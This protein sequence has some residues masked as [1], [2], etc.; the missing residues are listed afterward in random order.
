MNLNMGVLECE[1]CQD[2]FSCRIGMS[3]RHTQEFNITCKN[4]GSIASIVITEDKEISLAGVR[5]VGGRVEEGNSS[6]HLDLHLDFPVFESESWHPFSPFM[7]S[8]LMG[9]ESA[10]AQHAYNMNSLNDISSRYNFIKNTLN[11]YE[12]KKHDLFAR[13]SNEYLGITSEV[14]TDIGA[15]ML[16]FKLLFELLDPFLS[17]SEVNGD[18]G[19]FIKS[20]SNIS[21]SKLA[22]FLKEVTANKATENCILDAVKIYK[23]VLE[24]EVILR[25]A[26]F[27]DLNSNQS[28]SKLPYMLSSEG[29]EN[30][31]DLFKDI[32]EVLSRQL[33]FVAGINNLIKRGSHDDFLI[34]RSK[35]GNVLSPSSLQKFADLDFGKKLEFIDDSWYQISKDVADNQLRNSTAHFKWDYDSVNQKVTYFPKKEGLGRLQ[36][37]EISLLDYTNK[38]LASFRLMHRLNYLCHIINLKANNKI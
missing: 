36:S 12:R 33:S 20:M 28:R 11:F 27:V 10:V 4:C 19:N 29:F 32:S 3:N 21:S 16:L 31:Q 38:I 24:K 34:V 7:V 25:P 5:K 6:Y 15:E 26:L 8:A 35:K 18:I 23:S 2:T 13:N 30:I 22:P 17:A 14:S 37:N 9:G 1:E